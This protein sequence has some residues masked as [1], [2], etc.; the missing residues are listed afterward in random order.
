M[1]YDVLKTHKPELKFLL[2]NLRQTV[3]IQFLI[4]NTT[5]WTRPKLTSVRVIL[6]IMEDIN[7]FIKAIQEKSIQSTKGQERMREVFVAQSGTNCSFT[8]HSFFMLRNDL[9]SLRKLRELRFPT[10]YWNPIIISAV[11]YLQKTV[12]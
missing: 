6:V 2:L 7:V 4:N 11:N 8:L 9:S 1:N 3:R 12:Y 5:K 10:N